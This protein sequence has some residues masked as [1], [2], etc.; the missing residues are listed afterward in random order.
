M[1]GIMQFAAA[2]EVFKKNNNLLN[3]RIFVEGLWLNP[4]KT[5]VIFF[6]TT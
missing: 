1:V 2:F 3:C 5:S 6:Q 4:L